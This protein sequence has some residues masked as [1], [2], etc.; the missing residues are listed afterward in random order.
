[1]AVLG[2]VA[3]VDA[4]ENAEREMGIVQ[5]KENNLKPLVEGWFTKKS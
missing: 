3:D 1:M 2:L 4:V 5:I